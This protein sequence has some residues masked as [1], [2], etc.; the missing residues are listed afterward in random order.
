MSTTD[1][2]ILQDVEKELELMNHGFDLNAEDWAILDQPQRVNKTR[3]LELEEKLPITVKNELFRIANSPLH[4][5]GRRQESEDF[6]D[7]ALALGMDNIKAYIFSVALYQMASSNK[8]IL[9]LKNRSLATAGLSLAIIHNV[10]GFD[11]T[12]ASQVQLCA[13]VSEFGKIPFYI[14]RQKKADDPSVLKIM[15]EDFINIHHGQFGLK[16]IKLF[17]LPDFLVNLFKKESLIFFDQAHQLSITTIVRIA[18]LIV[19]DSFNRQNKLVITSVVDDPNYVVSGSAGSQLQTFFDA[20]GIGNL[21]EVIPFE[22][23][24]QEYTRKKKSGSRSLDQHKGH[25]EP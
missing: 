23:P 11:L 4:I 20:L 6:W 14:Y 15:T 18:K 21:L 10:L 1:E 8:D 12:L 2:S 9:L 3:I 17:H 5:R 13:L 24:A 25:S 19:R 22:T 7:V 16:M